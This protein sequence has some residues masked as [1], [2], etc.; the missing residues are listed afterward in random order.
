MGQEFYT[1]YQLPREEISINLEKVINDE[2]VET[3]E[4]VEED[5]DS[6]LFIESQEKSIKAKV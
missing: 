2:P 6:D 5:D 3:V 4:T 1:S